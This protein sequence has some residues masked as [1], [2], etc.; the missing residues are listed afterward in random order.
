MAEALDAS[1][2][3]VIDARPRSVGNVTVAR[4][5]PSRSAATW[6]RCVFW[7]TW[8]RSHSPAGTGFDVAPHP[9][10]G[11]SPVTYLFAD[12]VMHRDSVGSAQLVKPGA[13]N[14]MTAGK[15]IVHSERA[16]P[17]WRS[18]GGIMHGAQL[19]LGLFPEHEHGEPVVAH[20][21]VTRSHGRRRAWDLPE[22]R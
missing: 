18:T 1:I 14:L 21:W 9:H 11:L 12:E 3:L 5:I 19:W 22:R 13:L 4:L 20:H 7:I 10:I 17:E 16:Q 2:E 15:G 8:A 6:A